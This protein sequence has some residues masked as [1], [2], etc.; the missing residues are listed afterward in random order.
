MKYQSANVKVKHDLNIIGLNIPLCTAPCPLQNQNEFTYIRGDIHI[1]SYL[2]FTTFIFYVY[3]VYSLWRLF[4]SFEK[5][6]Q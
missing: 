2:T 5:N 1:S 6:G 4:L 3:Y